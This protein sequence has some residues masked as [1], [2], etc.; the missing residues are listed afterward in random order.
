MAGLA[1]PAAMSERGLRF[2]IVV[3]TAHGD[4]ALAVSAMMA[5][6]CDFIEKPYTRQA[7]LAPP[8]AR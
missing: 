6:A 4:V 5:G 3:V 7:S 2:P 8:R 1:P